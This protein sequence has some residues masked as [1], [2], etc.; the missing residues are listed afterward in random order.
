MEALMPY[1]HCPTCRLT[2]HAPVGEAAGAPCP[3][4]GSALSDEPRSLFP[5]APV[6]ARRRPS[7]QT[8]LT[9]EAVRNVMAARR[10]RFHRESRPVVPRP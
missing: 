2:V 1:Q 3:R 5:A 7:K 8:A 9:A 6:A 4:C 10:G